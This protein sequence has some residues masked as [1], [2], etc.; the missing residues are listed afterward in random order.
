MT[1]GRNPHPGDRVP[2]TRA[3]RS[4]SA[5]ARDA[6]QRAGHQAFQ[7]LLSLNGVDCRQLD[8]FSYRDVSYDGSADS[9]DV[10]SLDVDGNPI[11][12]A[13]LGELRTESALGTAAAC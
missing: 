2:A 5:R 12:P 3:Q 4:S 1:T 6:I 8:Q 7:G 11:G 9:I 10:A 13:Q